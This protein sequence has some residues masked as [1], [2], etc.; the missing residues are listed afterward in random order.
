MHSHYAWNI[1]QFTY[2]SCMC[3]SRRLRSFIYQCVVNLNAAVTNQVQLQ[4]TI[5]LYF[6]IIIP[7]TQINCHGEDNERH[8]ENL[9]DFATSILSAYT[10]IMNKYS[11][12]SKHQFS[13]TG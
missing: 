1:G 13:Q 8:Y 2:A 5:I 12:N 4:Y 9:N 7:S 11:L 10:T 6:P 3:Y